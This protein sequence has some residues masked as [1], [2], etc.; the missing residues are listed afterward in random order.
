LRVTKVETIR[1]TR[2]PNLLW[3][4]LHS[5]D[6]LIGLGETF[7][8]PA[9]VESVIHDVIAAFVLDRSDCYPESIWE[10]VFSY[11]NFFGYA[12]AE[13]R[14]LSAV[15][16]A[17]WDLMGQETGRPIYQLLGGKLRDT[18]PIYNTCVDSETYKDGED[19]L[20]RPG[21]LAKDLLVQG[22]KAMKVWPWDRF[23]PKLKATLVTGPAGYLAMG[24]SGSFLSAHDLDA[25]LSVIK[26][27]R[28]AAGEDMDIM[29]EGHSRWDLNCAIRI[30]RALEPYNVLWMEDM[31]KP[32]SVADLA[33]LAA[34]TRVPQCVSERLFTRYAYRQVLEAGA[35][36]IIMPDLI[37]TGG[38]TEGRKIAILA[39]TFHLPI[40]PH[41]CTGLV[42]IF[43]NLHICAVSANAMILE[44][45]RGFYDGWYRSVYTDNLKIED[46]QAS[47]PEIPGL[48]TRLKQEFLAETGTSVRVS[49]AEQNYA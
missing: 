24:P 47:F 2:L 9:A 36:H 23:A 48:G 16:I 28:D 11:C 15:D 6:G 49:V 39:D 3:V 20:R 38:I 43:A 18:I 17:L 21:A 30:G 7:Y 26:E 5:E 46:G 45:V 29:I 19:F 8:L 44:T 25:G 4:Q 22:I 42:A 37:W 41:D 35:A 14:A 12:G 13:M 34:E 33:R 10:Q 31:I 40:A 27:I 32:D 1:H